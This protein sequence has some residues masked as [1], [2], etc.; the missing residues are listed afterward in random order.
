M[1]LVGTQHI[2]TLN[3]AAIGGAV[4]R[5]GAALF[6][7]WE[8]WVMLAGLAAINVIWIAVSQRVSSDGAWLMASWPI[9]VLCA[10]VLTKLKPG[11]AGLVE[12]GLKL[13]MLF[14]FAETGLSIFRVFNHLANTT[15]LPLVDAQL[16][17]FDT[18]LG[19]DWLSY[20]QW[21]AS[22]AMIAN[23]LGLSYDAIYIVILLIALFHLMGGREGR[24]G[25]VAA[26]LVT[27]AVACS[28]VGGLFPAYGAMQILGTPDLIA[29][30][31]PGA[32]TYAI[33]ALN[34][35]RADEVLLL[36]SNLPGLTTCPSYHTALGLLAVYFCRGHRIALALTSLYAAVMIASTPVFGGH[37]LFDILAGGVFTVVVVSLW[38]LSAN[39]HAGAARRMGKAA[40][41]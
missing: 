27:S 2:R 14:S 6:P 19:F 17:A 12:A 40:V 39:V 38:R 34:N 22:H 29:S 30:L 11:R 16:L 1:H 24:A 13:F 21:V 28:A 18:W 5:V 9:A 25:E 20:A 26:L 37:Y 33:A 23:V 35:V 4:R 10:A 31:R 7:A 15:A 3:N 8:M 32:G 41:A 36:S